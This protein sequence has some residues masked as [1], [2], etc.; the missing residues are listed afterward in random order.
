MKKQE[1]VI[2]ATVGVLV[3]LGVLMIFSA[4]AVIARQNYGNGYYF[5]FR[6][7]VF[8]ALGVVLLWG[9]RRIDYH[10][11]ARLVLPLFILTLIL[12]VM[13][14]IPGV[15]H[16]VGG[17]S[18]WLRTPFCSLQPAEMG[19]LVMV[20]YF[21]AYAAK[22][23]ENMRSFRHG[24]LPMLVVMALFVVL[25]MLEPDFGTSLLIIV[26]GFMLSWVG[27]AR[28]VHLFSLGLL[29]LPLVVFGVCHSAYRLKRVMTFLDPW[30]DPTG[31]GFQVIQAM[32]AVGV[33]GI[34]GV[35]LGNGKQK[36]F[37]LPEPHTDFIVAAIGE[38]LGLLALGALLLIMVILLVSGVR[39]ALRSRDRFGLLLAVGLTFL[40][41]LQMLINMGVNLGVLPTKGLTY[42]FLSYGGT[43]L[44]VNMAA[45][46][47]LLN[48]CRQGEGGHPGG[49]R[50]GAE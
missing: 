28:L 34:S 7:L 22:K 27:G 11:W 21:A 5:L 44:L 4:S 40:V 32:I 29:G 36:L 46:G 19:K 43:S 2:L 50:S 6:Q 45:V 35:G 33:G 18:R 16:R 20:I 3:T 30:Q 39:V 23:G 12:L 25:L 15:G 24:L 41:V 47:I 49:R 37:F 9:C 10:W 8:L 1:I 48:I 13:V 38:E 17:A 14:L 31:N 42:P 26:L